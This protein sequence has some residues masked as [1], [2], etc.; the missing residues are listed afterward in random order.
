MT[1]IFEHFF[2][3]Q[4]PQTENVECEV[5]SKCFKLSIEK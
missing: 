4:N 1:E 5:T 2:F 3:L